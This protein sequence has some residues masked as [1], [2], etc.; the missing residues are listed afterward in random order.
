[1][2][3][4]IKGIHREQLSFNYMSLD[5]MIGENNKI[6]A[7]DAIVD[8]MEKTKLSFEHSE[9]KT[10]GRPPHDPVKLFKL[11]IYSYYEKIRSSR[12]IEKECTRN[13][14]AMWLIDGIV[15]DHK[16]ISD[17][18]KNNKKA[19]KTA[20]IEFVEICDVLGLLNKSLTAIDGSKFRAS[21][22]RK[23]HLTIKKANKKIEHFQKMIDEYNKEL[24]ENDSLSDETTKKI[25]N[26]QNKIQELES[27]LK[28]MQE[29]SISEISETD[30]DCRLMGL[31][32]MGY[33]LSYNVQNAVD[34]KNDI[35]IATDVVNSPAD[36]GQLYR[37]AEQAAEILNTTEGQPLTILA[38]KGYFES[39]DIQKCEDDPRFIAIV[40]KLDEKGKE[41]YKKS[42]FKYDE[43]N[44]C[45]ICPKNQILHRTGKK[46][47][48]Y[49]NRKACKSCEFKDQCTTDKRGRK[50]SRND[51]EEAMEVITARYIENKELYKQRQMI[52]EHPFGTVKRSLSFTYFLT[53]GF[54]NVKTENRLHMLTYNI[55]RV[56]NIFDTPSLVRLL[57]AFIVK[58]QECAIVFP[59]FLIFCV[60][61]SKN[62]LN[63]V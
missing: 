19:I 20:F 7:I 16:C 40:A 2:N 4:Y 48:N 36:Q 63:F 54:E 44:D 11:Y 3:A 6:R 29:Q 1:M 14:E 41:G 21:N 12:N 57:K 24:D 26:A 34:S 37:I 23:K 5:S 38:D 56:L 53:R 33:E 47:K 45:Y 46:H 61:F 15:P 17:F 25:E 55:K 32:N 28:L 39:K 22:A 35:I 51:H 58:K 13:I 62:K 30:P 27:T 31:A 42:D 9:T 60:I 18:R 59:A 49:C 43:E 52:V 8:S 50:I 10:T